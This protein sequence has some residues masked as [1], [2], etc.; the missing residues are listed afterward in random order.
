MSNDFSRTRQ[1]IQV[2]IDK[3]WHTGVQLYVSQG[4]QLLINV[5]IGTARDDEPLTADMLTLWLSAGKPLL[6]V[7]IAGLYEAGRIDI[8]LPV[9]HYIPEFGEQNKETITVAQLL[10][11]S[12]GLPVL[13]YKLD[14][15]SWD[16]KLETIFDLTIDDPQQVGNGAAYQ[17]WAS[18][19]LLAE[20]LQRVT[21]EQFSA[22]L[23]ENICL[24]L[25]MTRTWTSMPDDIFDDHKQQIVPLLFRTQGEMVLTPWHTKKG[26]TTPMPGGNYRG[27]ASDLGLFYEALLAAHK[28]GGDSI[29]QPDTVR[30]FTSRHRT[31]QHDET[32]QHIVDFGWGFLVDGNRYGVETVPYGYGQYC[33]PNTFGH[34]G[35]QSSI[36]FADPDHEL[37]V[38]VVANGMPGEPRHQQRNRAINNAIYEDL[39]LT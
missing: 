29:L 21:G 25:G 27:P 2:G 9:A 17:P 12:S 32:M 37:A 15:D 16:E 34:G 26:C 35:S 8:Q 24:P 7:A 13:P 28:P 14:Q 22:Y 20:M 5:G 3:G 39:G 4:Q 31:G 11:H 36:G 30:Q 1:A 19:L 33:S 10:S 6:A 23:H 38:V 18:W